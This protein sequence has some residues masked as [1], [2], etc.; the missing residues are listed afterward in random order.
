M[1]SRSSVCSCDFE[2]NVCA[3]ERTRS[4]FRKCILCNLCDVPCV[5]K[6]MSEADSEKFAETENTKTNHLVYIL[7]GWACDANEFIQFFLHS[8]ARAYIQYT[9]RWE[10]IF[11]L[12][13]HVCVAISDKCNKS[14]VGGYEGMCSEFRMGLCI[15][16]CI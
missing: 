7:F 14:A 2:I 15:C 16:E 12:F 4:T 8:S 6:G 5:G 3:T 10:S 1:L 11:L 13:M 9:F